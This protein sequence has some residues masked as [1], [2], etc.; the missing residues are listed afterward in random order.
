MRWFFCFF[1]FSL[2]AKPLDMEVS[3]RSAILM[4]ADT[5]AVLYEKHA[6]VPCYPGS[7]TKIATALYVLDKGVDLKRVATVSA[8]CLKGRPLTDRD[9][10][11][12]YW[13]DS[14]GTV[15]GLK[16]G[17]TLTLETLLYGCMLVSGNDAANVIA[18]SVGGTVPTFVGLL[19][20]YLKGL[21]CKNTQFAN[22]HGLPHP[23]HLSTAYDLALMTKKAL[24]IPHFRKVVSTLSYPRPK[25]N[26][27]PAGEIRLFNPLLKPKSRHYYPKAIGVKTGYTTLGQETLVAAAEHE[28]RTLIAVVLGCSKKTG[29]RYNDAR[30]LFETAFAQNRDK[31]R[32]M[33][34][35]NIF[36]K[37]MRGA[38]KPLKAAL[39]KPLTIEYFPAEEPK[40]KAALHWS[41]QSLP[42]RKGD[43][44]GEVY[45]LDENEILLQKGDLVALEELKGSFFFVLKE[46]FQR[47]LS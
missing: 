17:E 38:K 37:E 12:P 18:E 1:T 21:G 3:A 20:E 44:V 2:V 11:P 28:G 46:K 47:L 9:H 35:E 45:I 31:R 10:L 16:R 42:V 7:T 39:S 6:H 41:A 36:T 43:K 5:G 15:M 14:D 30:K 8:E 29:G 32:V 19:N 23:T 13:L 4:N 26:K 27:Q 34:P 25:T 24:T 22:P 40:C 33:G